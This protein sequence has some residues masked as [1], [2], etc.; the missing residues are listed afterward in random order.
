MRVA[1]T[2]L[3]TCPQMSHA[4]PWKWWCLHTGHSGGGPTF[5][6][7]AHSSRAG[8]SSRKSMAGSRR[9]VGASGGTSPTAA[10]P[11]TPEYRPPPVWSAGLAAGAAGAAA[12]PPAAAAAPPA[13]VAAIPSRETVPSI[14]SERC[15]QAASAWT[16]RPQLFRFVCY[17]VEVHS[18][19]ST[20]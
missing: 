1:R 19:A 5:A 11:D 7:G 12:P 9:S 16:L 18:A 2:V 20:R 6:H 15:A 13:T 8:S 14:E 10:G 17:S 4:V 3:P